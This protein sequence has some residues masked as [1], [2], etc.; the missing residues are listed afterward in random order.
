MTIV[1]WVI[2]ILFLLVVLL[3]A[4]VAYVGRKYHRIQGESRAVAAWSPAQEP[5]K[6]I[7]KLSTRVHGNA[8]ADTAIIALHGLASSG[9]Y[10]GANWDTLTDAS[11]CL[12]VP[13]LLGFGDSV[14]RSRSAEEH[15]IAHHTNAVSET[16][17]LAAPNAKQLH[18]VAHSF[19][20]I[21]ALAYA[22]EVIDRVASITLISPPLYASGDEAQQYI[23]SRGRVVALF[24]VDRMAAR[25]MRAIVCSRPVLAHTI[26]RFAA[27]AMPSEL[28]KRTHMHSWASYIGTFRAL[29][30]D[31]DN[32]RWRET[33]AMLTEKGIP[34]RVLV[35]ERD[36]TLDRS[37]IDALPQQAA[38]RPKTTT[39]P[40]VTVLKEHGHQVPLTNP[41]RCV[42]LVKTTIDKWRGGA[43]VTIDDASEK[44]ASSIASNNQ[45]DGEAAVVN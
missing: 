30:E 45:I 18:I 8:D 16:V 3:L 21:V 11:T 29:L 10:F 24:A 35:G 27:P 25:I 22:R 9:A 39:V 34:V 17:S 43:Q 4:L 37:I 33:L 41:A 31:L 23:V 28:A 2:G 19:G 1:F 32:K 13:D 40:V 7:G 6:I 5:A 26:A 42:E 15:S 36:F 38:K 44:L 12:V 14:D 20:S